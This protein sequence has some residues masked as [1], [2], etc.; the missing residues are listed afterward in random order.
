MFTVGVIEQQRIGY[1]TGFLRPIYANLKR[2]RKRGIRV[3]FAFDIDGLPQ[4]IDAILVTSERCHEMFMGYDVIEIRRLV[5]S[6]RKKAKR[7]A[8]FDMTDGSSCIFGDLV[9]AVD[10][11][12]K[13]W[14]LKDR[15]LYQRPF[16]SNRIYSEF[17]F[18]RFGVMDS[19]PH[20][21]HQG[22]DGESLHK[23][24]LGWNYGYL[25]FG[26]HARIWYA[27]SRRVPCTRR[28]RLP[29]SF[30][31]NS[32]RAC[33]VSMR[34]GMA[35]ELETVLFQRT[36]TRDI[37]LPRGVCSDR[38]TSKE[39][40]SELERAKICVSPFGW[41]EVCI[42][43][44][45]SWISGTALLKPELSHMNTFPEFFIEGETYESYRW[46]CSDIEEKV[47]HLLASDR[48]LVLARNGQELYRELGHSERAA[49]AFVDRFEKLICSNV[50]AG[51]N[52]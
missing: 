13:P 40:F 44:F 46:D 50:L 37:L 41:G 45:E 20:K 48:W 28:M 9:P 1:R 32:E 24:V 3:H 43:D 35:Y 7:I 14:T 52:S 42:R 51:I 30:S 26:K 10:V 18:R 21:Q 25:Q 27:V 12:L 8:F 39:Y 2:L 22:V 19:H 5:E 36:K 4:G 31:F 17:Y 6:C 16:Y 47:D 15:K 49:T 23:V 33:N 29:V 38:V 11:Y 34:L